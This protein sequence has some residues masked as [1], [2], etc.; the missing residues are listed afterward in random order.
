[1]NRIAPY[2][3]WIGHATEG[4]DF[5]P[6]LDEEIQ[7]VVDLAAEEPPFLLPRDL[8]SCRF[9]LVDGPG[10]SDAMLALAIGTVARLAAI[11]VRTLVRCGAGMSRSPAVV[12]AALALIHQ[13][14]AEDWLTRITHL[15]RSDVSPGLWNE[16]VRL[17]PT[18]F[19]L[20]KPQGI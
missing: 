7:A 6:I 12:A 1:M 2:P 9:P 4:P 5:V 16:I 10:N 15:H 8:I 13:E 3:I 17:C 14:P 20:P 11:E 19:H 18:V